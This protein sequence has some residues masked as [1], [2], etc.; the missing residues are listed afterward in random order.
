MSLVIDRFEDNSV[1]VLETLD[2]ESIYVPRNHLPE[3]AGEGD[4]VEL[5]PEDEWDGDVRYEL[6]MAATTERLEHARTLRASLPQAAD[7]DIEL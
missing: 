1:A 5:V 2:G 6:D 7:G 3:E 4:V